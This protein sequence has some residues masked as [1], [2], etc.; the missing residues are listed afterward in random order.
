VSSPAGIK[1]L[2]PL[3]LGELIDRCAIFWRAHLVPLFGLGL[4][5]HLFDYILKKSTA[6]TLERTSSLLQNPQQLDARIQED[7]MGVMGEMGLMMLLA[8]LLLVVLTWSYWLSTLVVARYVVPIQLGQSARPADGLR[9][10]LQRLGSLTG[11]YLLSLLWGLGVGLLMM[12]PGL[13]LIALGAF[14]ASGAAGSGAPLAGGLV[15]A[16]GAILLSLGGMAAFLWYFLRF[17]VLGPVF[18][19]EDL[20][21]LGAFRRSGAL[22]SGR[23]AP[24]FM[25]LVK[26]RAMI[27]LTAVGGIIIAVTLIFSAPGLIVHG[28]YGRLS[29]PSAAAANPIP[30]TLLVPVELFEV[31]GQ[32]IFLPLALVF[33]AMF[34]LDL[35]MRREGLDLE[36]RLAQRPPAP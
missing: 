24:G 29:D 15:A 3:S 35:R 14:M 9:R 28:V 19:M 27:L 22:L 25:G 23:V 31:L 18:A 12:I 6:L 8:I 34:Y 5:F 7:P 17:S 16:F 33:S 4:G 21:A 26:V 10:G 20:S 36:H 30:Q 32:S 2:R 1:D 11:A 13:I